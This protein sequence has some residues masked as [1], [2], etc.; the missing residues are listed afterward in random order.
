M[1]CVH[2][3]P[4]PFTVIRVG[5]VIVLIDHPF[6]GDPSSSRL[7]SSPGALW[8]SFYRMWVPHTVQ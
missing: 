2:C 3:R 1:G 5:V 7:E 4:S 6:L 8:C